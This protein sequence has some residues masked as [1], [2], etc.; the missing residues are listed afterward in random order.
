MRNCT[1]CVYAVSQT[2]LDRCSKSSVHVACALVV[3]KAHDQPRGSDWGCDDLPSLA[4]W[5]KECGLH[6]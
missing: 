1:Y 6:L 3:A 5:S 4:L 2:V